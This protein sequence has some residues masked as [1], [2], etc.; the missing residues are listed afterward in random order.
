MLIG[1][2]IRL[3]PVRQKDVEQVDTTHVNISK[4]GDFFPTGVQSESGFWVKDKGLLLIVEQKDRIIGH[5]ELFKTVDYLD[6]YELSYQVY[7]QAERGKGYVT[8]AVS[9]LVG[10][11]FGRWKMNRIWLIIHPEN[12]ASRRVAEKCGFTHEGTGRGAWYHRGTNHDVEV[13]ALLRSEFDRQ[14]E[15]KGNG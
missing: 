2:L 5:I 12:Q 11:L 3:R 8:D 6:E 4:R 10:C 7:E 13:Y 14:V 9:L 15:G 1:E